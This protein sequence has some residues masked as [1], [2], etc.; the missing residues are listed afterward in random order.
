MGLSLHQLYQTQISMACNVTQEKVTTGVKTCFKIFFKI[1][2]MLRERIIPCLLVQ[3]RGLVKTIKF[4]N[5]KYVGDPINTVRIFNEKQADELMVLDI[6]ASAK[7]TGPCFALIE[8]LAA[9][10]SMPLCYGGIK[11]AEQVKQIVNM[12]I[13]KVAV[14]VLFEDFS[15]LGEM[16]SS[17]GSQSVVVVFDIKKSEQLFSQKYEIYT[18]NGT[19]LMPDS[20]LEMTKKVQDAGVGVRSFLILLIVTAQWQATTFN[21][22][23]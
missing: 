15:V 20:P 2:V 14:S 17:V 3:N 5:P 23:S 4:S 16:V 21:M 8:K 10:C 19:K 22:Q 11:N 7:N 12:G 9:E 13:E 1:I 6:D 18:H